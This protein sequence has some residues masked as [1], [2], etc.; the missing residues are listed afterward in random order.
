MGTDVKLKVVRGSWILVMFQ[1]EGWQYLF[2]DGCG[3]KKRKELSPEDSSLSIWKSKLLFN[4]I[5]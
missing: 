4:E 1:R 5:E 2:K 3:A